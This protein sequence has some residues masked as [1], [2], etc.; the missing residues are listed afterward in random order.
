MNETKIREALNAVNQNPKNEKAAA[1]LRQELAAYRVI[2]R[3]PNGPV[4]VDETLNNLAFALETGYNALDGCLAVDELLATEKPKIEADP[5]DGRPLRAGKTVTQP[6]VNWQ[7]VTIDRRRLAVLAKMRGELP[8][9]ASSV[10]SEMIAYDLAQERLPAPWPRMELEMEKLQKAAKE[11]SK[12]GRTARDVLETIEDGLWFQ[13]EQKPAGAAPRTYITVP[14]VTPQPLAS[15]PILVEGR[16]F[17][18]L[19]A[20]L[21]KAFPASSVFEGFVLDFFPSVKRQFTNGMERSQQENLLFA[22]YSVEEIVMAAISAEPSKRAVF[23]AP[24][25][26]AQTDLFI[27]AADRDQ[28]RAEDLYKHCVNIKNKQASWLCPVGANLEAWLNAEFNKARVIVAV[29]SADLLFDEGLMY[30]IQAAYKAGRRVVPWIARPCDWKNTFLAPLRE[31]PDEEHLA[32]AE[33][34]RILA[35]M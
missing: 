9:A 28:R 1:F 30:L 33:I 35:N 32:S 27:V 12:E 16:G 4:D 29:V 19:R 23:E 25:K 17:P 7:P 6:I 14:A 5:V 31:M 13:R 20:A 26:P 15:E 18:W 34:R 2:A 3:Q 11:Q 10:P 21:Q 24:A 22:Y 8:H